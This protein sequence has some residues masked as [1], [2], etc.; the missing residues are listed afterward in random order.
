MIEHFYQSK[1]CLCSF[2]SVSFYVHERNR[3]VL[4]FHYTF[5]KCCSRAAHQAWNPCVHFFYDFSLR[6]LADGNREITVA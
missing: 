1:E 5:K 2:M 6:V 4:A 3:V